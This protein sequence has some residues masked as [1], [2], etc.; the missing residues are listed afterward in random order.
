MLASIIRV[1]ETLGQPRLPPQRSEI[2]EAD[3]ELSPQ[4][5]P[6][7]VAGGPPVID[8][9]RDP[10]LAV[11]PA[12]ERHIGQAREP[13]RIRRILRAEEDLIVPE[14]DFRR[15]VREDRVRIV[16]P[17]LNVD[18]V[19]RGRDPTEIGRAHV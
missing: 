9:I 4:D 14:M 10:P 19:L 12:M 15:L 8:P 11:R 5:S 3:S 17:E 2:L 6:C 18:E 13:K 16:V 7:R 1:S